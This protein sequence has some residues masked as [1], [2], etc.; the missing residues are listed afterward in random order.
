MYNT[1]THTDTHTLIQWLHWVAL[2]MPL[3]ASIFVLLN[4]LDALPTTFIY[5]YL[6]FSLSHLFLFCFLSIF[7]FHMFRLLEIMQK[8]CEIS[9]NMRAIRVAC[10]TRCCQGLVAG[11]P[12]CVCAISRQQTKPSSCCT[13][14]K[15]HATARLL[16][17]FMIDR[18]N[19]IDD[20]RATATGTVTW[21]GTRTRTR[22]RSPCR[23]RSPFL[24]T[25]LA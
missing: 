24:A 16:T 17:W 7:C 14:D 23:T 18:P 11:G 6:P 25:N 4:P 10:G 1:H 8:L 2:L 12:L 21:T 19:W 13:R 9:K 3:C 5:F 15:A 20:P 22:T